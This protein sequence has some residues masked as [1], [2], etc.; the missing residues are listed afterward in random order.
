MAQRAEAPRVV[1]VDDDRDIAEIV[2]AVLTVEGYE[3][4]CLYDL[5]DDGLERAVGRIEP[6]VVL[7]DSGESAEYGE[8]WGLAATLATRGRSVPVVM[9]SAHHG[10]VKDARENTSQRATD[11]GFAAIIEK[12]FLLDDLLVAVAPAAGKSVPFDRSRSAEEGRTK[13][14]VITLKARGATDIRPS[15][16]RE[17]A[18]FR[19]P[20]GT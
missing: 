18:M 7:L 8:G 9:F 15:N 4:S 13:S 17:W 10:D 1:C 2:Q 16:M 3:V 20:N 19:D 11:A 6:D 12:P 14:V 5:T